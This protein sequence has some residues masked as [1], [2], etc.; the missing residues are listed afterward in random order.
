MPGDTRIFG[1][2]LS[3]T[4]AHYKIYVYD[5]EFVSGIGNFPHV[6]GDESTGDVWGDESTGEVWGWDALDELDEVEGLQ[7]HYVGVGGF[8]LDYET[9]NET[10]YT[11]LMPSKLSFELMFQNEVQETFLNALADS[12]EGQFLVRVLKNDN[13]FWAGVLVPDVVQYEDQYY[14]FSFKFTAIDGLSRLKSIPYPNATLVNGTPESLLSIIFEC[15]SNLETPFF[16]AAN[17]DYLINN[18]DWWET[19]HISAYNVD[20]LANTRINTGAIY[21]ENSTTGEVQFLSCFDMLR[22]IA[23]VFGAR[24]FLADGK[25]WFMQVT[26]YDISG[27]VQRI[28]DKSQ[29]L[30]F[31]INGKTYDLIC[32]QSTLARTE[33]RYEFL[34]PL[35]KVTATYKSRSVTGT[36][37]QGVSWDWI[38]DGTVVTVGEVSNN[39]GV[40]K[41]KLKFIVEHTYRFVPYADM[42][43][44]S[45]SRHHFAITL[46][47]GS[48]YFVGDEDAGAAWTTTPGVFVFY[49]DLFRQWESHVSTF[50][51]TTSEIPDSGTCTFSFAYLQT[52]EFP[53]STLTTLPLQ[54]S[55]IYDLEP[56]FEASMQYWVQ[57]S[58]LFVVLENGSEN[59]T[60]DFL[61]Y[62]ATNTNTSNTK[63]VDL[64][65]YFGDGP[66][67]ATAARMETYNG[68]TWAKSENW[69]IGLLATR[70]KKIL[71]LLVNRILQAQ[72]KPRQKYVGK[73][74]TATGGAFY[75]P[76]NRLAI[77]GRY[78][79][80]LGGTFEAESDTWQNLHIF[81]IAIDISQEPDP[82]EE[83]LFVP[84]PG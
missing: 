14:P 17:D 20:P 49:T 54:I 77:N 66:Y 19:R 55:T 37:L 81:N 31:S 35:K 32:N 72:A 63:E 79:V 34:P 70:N 8:T 21:E 40:A 3:Y 73:L 76:Y 22:Q 9:E 83:E 48:Y 29:T 61:T 36:L 10:L 62:T 52:E 82:V 33:G 74:I 11:P 75:H 12:Y 58:P 60:F 2:F 64:L 6:I 68:A 50:E 25:W 28:Y 51:I 71:Q 30:K 57:V 41:I 13:L 7:T 24:L 80:F 39:G 26:E 18:V 5:A 27:Q 15:L 78:Y 69:G 84:T 46:R 43:D 4:G 23:T 47:V 38:T 53:S 65:V 16:W 44:P 42:P 59:E 1:E 56:E 67:G 45:Q